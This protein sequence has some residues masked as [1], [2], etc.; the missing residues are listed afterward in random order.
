MKDVGIEKTKI[1]YNNRTRTI[2]YFIMWGILIDIALQ[3]I[4]FRFEQN[5]HY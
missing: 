2:F 1:I 4:H 3:T 5:G